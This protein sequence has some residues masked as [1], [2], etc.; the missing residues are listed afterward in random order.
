[1]SRFIGS[2]FLN[3]FPYRFTNI[4]LIKAWNI[5]VD[6]TNNNLNN[7]R[8]SPKMAAPHHVLI[9]DVHG[10]FLQLLTPLIQ[11]GFISNV[12]LNKIDKKIKINELISLTIH[13]KSKF[14]TSISEITDCNF[15]Q[16]PKFYKTKIIY[17]GDI[18]DHSIHGMDLLLIRLLMIFIKIFPR[19][20]YWCFG[21]HDM[22]LYA[23]MAKSFESKGS[24][25][26]LCSKIESTFRVSRN[27][28]HAY[29]LLFGYEETKNIFVEFVNNEHYK[30]NLLIYY[31][32]DY[33]SCSHRKTKSNYHFLIDLLKAKYVANTECMK[34]RKADLDF[35]ILLTK[36]FA[37]GDTDDFSKT[38]YYGHINL[39]K[40]KMHKGM[41]IEKMNIAFDK[42]CEQLENNE[43]H[44]CDLCASTFTINV[45]KN[46]LG[47]EFISHV[48]LYPEAEKNKIVCPHSIINY[49]NVL[50]IMK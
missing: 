33:I 35:R 29:P 21:N 19:N 48:A 20:V 17:L 43:I 46:I 42:L 25:F 40:H 4:D 26:E 32:D 31:S 28:T 3:Q 39:L 36:L 11:Y 13:A 8:Y 10:S 7:I 34:K 50:D 41:T 16:I 15:E 47:Y 14:D 5:Y 24:T 49:K 27:A 12:K 30:H 9:G 37:S 22:A 44:C 38:Y 2:D 45:D 23:V 1:M 6:I 18:V